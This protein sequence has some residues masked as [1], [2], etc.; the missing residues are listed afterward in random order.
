MR[1]FDRDVHNGT[2]E[3]Q[4]GFSEK[5][6]ECYRESARTELMANERIITMMRSNNDIRRML[7]AQDN[8]IAYFVILL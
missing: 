7:F 4:Y 6:C 2:N 5:E 1:N 8:V 3:F